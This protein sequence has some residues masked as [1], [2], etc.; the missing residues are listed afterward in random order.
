MFCDYRFQSTFF[1]FCLFKLKLKTIK[2]K[3]IHHH[4]SYFVK[5]II[6]LLFSAKKKKRREKIW[7][8]WNL[9]FGFLIINC[10]QIH[11][12]WSQQERK[13]FVNNDFHIYLQIN[14][15]MNSLFFIFML[16]FF[17]FFPFMYKYYHLNWILYRIT[18]NMILI[19]CNLLLYD[20]T[21]KIYMK[22][23]FHNKDTKIC[24]LNII[25]Y[26]DL[27]LG[28]FFYSKDYTYMEKGDK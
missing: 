21:V 19:T 3:N 14:E 17:F 10:S 12:D 28:K 6:L 8:K 26:I 24:T 9:I 7:N 16:V 2:G 5:F 1:T 23:M 18:Y 22:R 20:Y 27:V 15:G 13:I 25:L 11:F 4:H